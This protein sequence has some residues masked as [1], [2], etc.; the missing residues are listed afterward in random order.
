MCSPDFFIVGAPKAGTT[1]LYY[2]LKQHPEVFFPDIKEPNFF[3]ASE[4][5]EQNLYYDTEIIAD[6]RDYQE[7]YRDSV[8]IKL[9]GDAS[10]SYLFYPLVPRRI[11]EMVPNA[12]IIIMLRNPIERAY[13]HY[14]MDKKLGYVNA[15]FEDIVARRLAHRFQD[16]YYQQYVKLGQYCDQVE[17]YLKTFGEKQVYIILSEDFAKDARSCLRQ[18][19][20]FLG[21]SSECEVDLERHNVFGFPGSKI[22]GWI[23]RSRWMRGVAG[24]VLP[25]AGRRFLK[26]LVLS[27]KRKPPV[28]REAVNTLWNIY[29]KDVRQLSDLIGRN[30]Y[31]CWM[32]HG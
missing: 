4:I 16:L 6:L 24:L 26:G 9:S 31:D 20:L 28:S 13:S 29:E 5:L 19:C 17:R 12:K 14:L 7:L 11:K 1:S 8:G 22:S 21:I 18:A 32:P 10:V 3:S 27:D 25:S 2:Y 30:L 23:Y 15:G